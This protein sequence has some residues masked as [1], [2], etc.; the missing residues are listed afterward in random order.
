MAKVVLPRVHAM[1]LCDD[2]EDSP[3]EDGVYN[4]FGVRTEIQ[5]AAFPHVHPQLYAY[6][7]VS[8]H[9]GTVSGVIVVVNARTDEELF[10]QA[11]PQV[12]LRDPLSVVSV[13]VQFADCVFP[14]PGLYYSRFISTKS[15]FASASCTLL[16][17]R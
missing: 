9:E 7:Q 15:S 2:V 4:L 10:H 11:T 3:A 14:E 13:A 1:I 17:A 8:G 16:K 6:L 12:A 5:A